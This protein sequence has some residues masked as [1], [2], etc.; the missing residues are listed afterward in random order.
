MKAERLCLLCV[1]SL[2]SAG[3]QLWAISVC[4]LVLAS[5]AFAAQITLGWDTN[6]DPAVAGY[7]LYYGS[8]SEQYEGAIDV[9]MQDTYTL[10]DLEDGKPYHFAITAYDMDGN[11]S[12]ISEEIVHDRSIADSEVDQEE[13]SLID[14]EEGN[15]DEGGSTD[16]D[17]TQVS[18]AGG[19]DDHPS[20]R[21]ES[22]SDQEEQ[23]EAASADGVIPQS[24]LSI[25]FVDSE[26]FVGDGA[27]EAAIDGD[28]ETFWRTEMGAKAPRHPHE[29][30]IALG[31]SYSVRG[32][33]LS[34]T[35]RRQPGW[36]GGTIQ[37]LCQ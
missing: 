21:V 32:G 24:Q 37:F 4:S 33:S 19:E 3:V 20:D 16:M 36:N 18:A 14:D 35:P 27:A 7:I 17:V 34:S 10:T 11:E 2:C 26:P 28:P 13:N 25:V 8:A 6:N 5:S 9:G 31:A 12:E 15:A 22:A 29:L 1:I 23:Q 30:V